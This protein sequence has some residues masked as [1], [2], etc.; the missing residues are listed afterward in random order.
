MRHASFAVTAAFALLSIAGVAGAQDGR[1]NRVPVRSGA[2][3]GAGRAAGQQ[4]PMARELR[5]KFAAVI[6][7][8][9]NL[10]DEN[11]KRLQQTDRKYEQ[12]RVQLR[13]EERETRQALRTALADTANVDQAKVAQYMDQLTLGQRRRADLLEA[14][15]KELATFLSPVQRAKLQGLREQLGQRVKQLQQQQGGGGRKGIQP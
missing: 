14:E 9:L 1:V 11:A 10:S 13:R 12:Q 3:R 15:Q 4:P 2:Q 5:Q 8:Q 6:Q 7:R